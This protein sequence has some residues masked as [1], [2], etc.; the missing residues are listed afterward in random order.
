MT[1]DVRPLAKI[2]GILR[3]RSEQ[4]NITQTL[5][6]LIKPIEEEHGMAAASDAL[7]IGLIWQPAD[8]EMLAVGVE[9]LFARESWSEAADLARWSTSLGQNSAN[10][11]MTA[12]ACLFR[13]RRLQAARHHGAHAERLSPGNAGAKFLRGRIL[14]SLGVVEDG[15]AKIDQAAEIDGKFSFAARVLH[16]G[17]TT[18]DFEQVK[19]DVRPDLF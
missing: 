13:S 15:L 17:L 6:P 8:A 11:H 19:R 1:S 16:L 10:A 18:R 7:R 9:F 5:T 2:A 3:N 4:T 14:V 12:A